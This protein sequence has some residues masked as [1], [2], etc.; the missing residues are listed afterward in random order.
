MVKVGLTGG[1]GSGKSTV[2]RMF[3]DEGAQ[4]IDFDYLARLV[5]EPD[6]PAWRDIVDYFGRDILSSDRTLNRP[7]LARI[8]FSDGTSRKVLEDFTHPRI[9]EERDTIIEAIKRRHPCAIV[10][11][12]VPLLFELG[13]RGMFDKVILAYVPRAVQIERVVKR[14]GLAREDV[15]KRLNAQIPIEDKR[16]LSDYVIDNEGSLHHTRDQVT[17]VTHELRELAKKKGGESNCC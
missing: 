1:I 8:V 9:F 10:M 15:E 16:S 7:A 5:V 4:V 6:K 2:A 17:K 11:M 3:Q 14:S 13:L 12:D